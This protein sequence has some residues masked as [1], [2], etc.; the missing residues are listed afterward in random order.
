MKDVGALPSRGMSLF[1]AL[2]TYLAGRDFFG[3]VN[4]RGK[5]RPLPAYDART[6]AL[7]RFRDF[8][9][10]L[11]WSRPGNVGEPE[12]TYR[13]PKEDI[14][15]DQPDDPASMNFPSLAFLPARGM[16]DQYT[17]GPSDLIEESFGMYGKNTV[18]LR[19]GEYIELFL[20]EAWGSHVSD[21]RSILAGIQAV[22]RMNQRS[23]ALQLSLPNYYGRV[24]SFSLVDSQYIDD[25]DVV[26]GR[27]RG[28][29]AI[30]LRVPEVMLV[31]AITMRPCL[32]IEIVDELCG[33]DVTSTCAEAGT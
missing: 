21:R 29:V 5:E 13:I 7:T 31:D 4:P 26:R 24:A 18:L 30:E 17:L 2:K 3:R 20:V 10:E 16:H 19:Q 25:P 1:D 8:L 27:R 33:Q 12:I 23:N 15:P 11:E 9:A 6:H 22:M 32:C 14:Y 28:Q